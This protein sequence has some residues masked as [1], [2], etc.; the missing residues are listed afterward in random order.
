MRV[1]RTVPLFALLAVTL[2]SAG[3]QSEEV[4][5]GTAV[6]NP[7]KLTVSI[8]DADNLDL[9]GGVLPISVLGVTT[10]EGED[11]VVAQ[12]VWADPE[13]PAMFALPALEIC[14]MWMELSETV[15][16]TGQLDDR[17]ELDLELEL[18]EVY[19]ESDGEVNTSEQSLTLVLGALGWLDGDDFIDETGD[20]VQVESDDERAEDAAESLAMGAVLIED[21]N[22]NGQFDDDEPVL[23]AADDEEWLVVEDDDDDGDDD[24]GC[25]GGSSALILV[26][27]LLLGFRRR[28]LA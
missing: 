20:P 27:G 25:G 26:P 3:C 19:V 10:C 15:E 8:A 18:D 14:E 21:E 4:A 28:M 22:D 1:K 17:R 6:G 13:L 9:S 16:L 11:V 24:G 7:G 2:F 5:E 23:A 12:D